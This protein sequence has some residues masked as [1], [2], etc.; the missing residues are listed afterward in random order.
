MQPCDDF[1][2]FLSHNVHKDLFL[3]TYF[4]LS[5]LGHRKKIFSVRNV[6]NQWYADNS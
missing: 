4:S 2:G 1:S 3:K 5:L 6:K